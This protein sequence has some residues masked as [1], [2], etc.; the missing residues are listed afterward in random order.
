MISHVRPA[1]S[2]LFAALIM[3]YG[4]GA[5]TGKRSVSGDEHQSDSAWIQPASVNNLFLDSAALAQFLDTHPE[6]KAQHD[7]LWKFY[8]P[9]NYQ[10]AW[11]NNDGMAEQA[12]NF[13]NMLMNYREEGITDTTVFHPRLKLLYDSL[14]GGAYVMQGVD[15]VITETE[16]L[17]SASF[18][19]YAQEIWG[20]IGDQEL[21]DF[22]W[23]I[24][25]KRLPYVAILDSMLSNPAYF[26]QQKTVYRQ[27]DLLKTQ[28]KKYYALEQRHDWETIVADK[29]SYKPGDSSQVFCTI[30]KRL[31]LLEDL[32][33]ADTLSPHY[34]DQLEAAVKNFQERHGLAVDGVIGNAMIEA[35]N[36]PVS[37]RIQQIIVNMER[38]RW[39]PAK[40]E[41]DYL[42]VNIPEFRLH[43]YEHDSMMWECNVV[44]GSVTNQT[45]IFNDNMRYIVFSPYWNIP[46]SIIAKEI[47]PAAKRNANYISS[48][49]M[50]VVAGG[51]VISPSAVNWSNYSGY[52]F[53]YAIRQK[54][55][56]NNSLGRVKFLFPNN[57]SIYLHDT[58]SKSLFNEPARAFSHGCIRVGEPVRLAEYLL[59]NDSLWTPEKIAVAMNSN[60][61]TT[62]SLKTPVPV[63]IAYFTAWV[64]RKGRLNFRKDIYG[65]DTRLAKV[66]F[67]NPAI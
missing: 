46:A 41:G 64:D 5:E 42:A 56:P 18:F 30:R 51:K 9:R 22:D 43:V 25:R 26:A 37:L 16:L 8:Q 38:S 14:S 4:C 61:E 31:Y 19:K 39:V 66:L 36:I 54:P 34:D 50:E 6:F 45:V 2:F 48:H 24:K 62:V 13:M 57:Y 11:F 52:N 29:K 44:V 32:T 65:H 47:L 55:G 23:F 21:K 60:K 28:L 49:N 59:R 40:L 10:F 63:F 17:L 58:P 27:Y 53:P 1:L 35:L 7:Q 15:P 33:T 67:N 12:A 3:L 20:G